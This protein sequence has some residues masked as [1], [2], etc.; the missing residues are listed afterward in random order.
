MGS[1]SLSV[2]VRKMYPNPDSGHRIRTNNETDDLK[3]C[4]LEYYNKVLRGECDCR[5]KKGR[6]RYERARKLVPS[7]LPDLPK[8][9]FYIA[10]DLRAQAE[11]DNLMAE[12]YRQ[13]ERFWHTVMVGDG[14]LFLVLVPGAIIGGGGA[15]VGGA[16]AEEGG[17]IIQFLKELPKV[18][19]KAA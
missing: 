16:A 4:A 3:D 18:L 17:E 13:K 12:S 14:L 1:L 15:A 8:L 7:K 9:G 11:Q 2:S 6:I 19:P 10:D 5:D